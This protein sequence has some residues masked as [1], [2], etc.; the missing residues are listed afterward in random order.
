M[1]GMLAW[2]IRYVCF[3]S[4]LFGF[5]LIGLLL[6]GFCYSFLYVGAYM[7]VDKRAP[8]DLKASAQSLLTFLLIGI[9]WFVGAKGAGFMKDTYHADVTGMPAVKISSDEAQDS[10]NLPSWDDPEAGDSALRYLDLS[11]TVKRLRGITSEA[12][13]DL[14][15]LMDVNPADGTITVAEIEQFKDAD[16]EV[17]GMKYKKTDLI[18]TFKDIHKKLDVDEAKGINREQWMAVQVDKWQPIW[19]YPSTIAFVVVAFFFI[20]FREE[21]DEEEVPADAG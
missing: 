19:L 6:H 4:P 21:K 7:Y 10:A 2:G 3:S 9:G 18:A 13:P 16:F 5:A 12:K 11:G 15:K 1:I 14:A 8:E 20:G 17:G